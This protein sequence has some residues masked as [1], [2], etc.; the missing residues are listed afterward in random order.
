MA[1]NASGSNTITLANYITASPP[2]VVADFSGAPTSGQ[3]PL[4]V[5]FSDLSS[6]N[7]TSW[8]WDFGD[9][10][11]SQGQYPNHIYQDAGTYTVSLTVSG[12]GGTQIKTRAGYIA[13]TSSA[14]LPTPDFSADPLSG[15]LPL[16]VTFT[17]LSSGISATSTW[18]WN[19]GDGQTSPAR[20]P[21]HTY[22]SPGTYTVSLTVT[23]DA[24][25]ATATRGNYIQARRVKKWPYTLSP[26]KRSPKDVPAGAWFYSEVTA[27]ESAGIV[28][29]YPDLQFHPE[30]PVTRD[31]VAVFISRA[32]AGGDA[33]VPDGP[34]LPSFPD[35]SPDDWAYKYVEYA[36][37]NS[38]AEGY[39]DHGYHP[40]DPVNR[41][42]MAVFVAR[43]MV[44]PLGDVGLA[45]FTPP[46]Q[47]AFRD[48]TPISS[49]KWCYEHVEFLASEGMVAGYSDGLYRPS[50]AVSRDQMSVYIARAFG[51]VE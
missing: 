12:A 39:P 47:P 32:I 25:A 37:A 35:V 19:F 22:D 50:D 9:G 34:P 30:L 23:N 38:I 21:V 44:D 26:P 8:S 42:Q 3:A 27:L 20:S 5:N 40:L 13:V 29:G 28:L 36:K 16:T 48:V 7:P 1:T 51:L 2:S 14:A 6:G 49:A 4:S 45:S 41:G 11:T 43:S 24:G 17:D 31:Q 33:A 18:N 10:A 46:D 15:R